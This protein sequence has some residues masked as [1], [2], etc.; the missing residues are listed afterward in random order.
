[1]RKVLLAAV[2]L[3]LAVLAMIGVGV[4]EGTPAPQTTPSV[5]PRP[6]KW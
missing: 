4:V 6:P 2:G 5:A 1:M 3:L